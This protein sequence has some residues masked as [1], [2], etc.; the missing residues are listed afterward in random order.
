MKPG[1]DI[2][3]LEK[4]LRDIHLRFETYDTDIKL[5]VQPLSKMHLY[6]ADGAAAGI[7]TVR[8]FTI[9]ALFIQVIA[10]INYV[11]L[12]TARSMLH[13]KEVSLRKIVGAGWSQL[14]MQFIVETTLLFLLASV[15]AVMLIYLLMPA[16]NTISGKEL[17]FNLADKN[18][19]MV[20]GTSISC[21][22]IV[23]GI[24]PALLLS[25]F[26]LIEAL[27]GKISKSIGGVAFQRILVVN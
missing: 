20:F 11:N 1:S 14:F 21:N 26:R 4:K 15:L 17:K 13:S 16:F 23:S 2:P 6:K 19:W 3:L 7:E 8:I 27:K 5:L 25:S 12:S 9:V 10:C 24:Y 22:L 18:F